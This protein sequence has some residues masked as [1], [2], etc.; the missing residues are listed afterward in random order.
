LTVRGDQETR[1]NKIPA[2]APLTP[3]QVKEYAGSY[4]T[5]ELPA[6]YVLV[7]EEG[8]LIFK[9]R[10][11]PEKPLKLIDKDKFL[12]GYGKMEFIRGKHKK[13]AGFCL[14]AGRVR[15]QFKKIS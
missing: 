9:H 15:I 7:Y 1:L 11:A 10:N 5:D 12:S 4:Y 14:D 2:V 13:I 6:T 3:E 8:K